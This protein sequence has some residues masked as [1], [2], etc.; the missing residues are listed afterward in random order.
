MRST[1]TIRETLVLTVKDTGIMEKKQAVIRQNQME[2]W[3]IEYTILDINLR[4]GI[5]STM[6]VV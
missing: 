5:K 3:E 2:I 6:N 4:G 1:A